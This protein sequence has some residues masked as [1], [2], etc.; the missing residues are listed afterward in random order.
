MIGHSAKRIVNTKVPVI[1]AVTKNSAR[2]AL[3]VAGAAPKPRSTLGV[4]RPQACQLRRQANSD[5]EDEIAPWESVSRSPLAS[6][7]ARL[8]ERNDFVPQAT[9]RGAGWN[10]AHDPS[11]ETFDS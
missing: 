9:Q 2:Q 6:P 4:V 11:F 3:A 5:D 7:W 8:S 1:V 10:R